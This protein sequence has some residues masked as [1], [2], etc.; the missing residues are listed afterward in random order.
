MTYSDVAAPQPEEVLTDE[1]E[2]E[3]T[4]LHEPRGNDGTHWVMIRSGT[5]LVRR[6]TYQNAHDLSRQ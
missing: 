3:W 1:D 2:R 5:F 4:V 6:L